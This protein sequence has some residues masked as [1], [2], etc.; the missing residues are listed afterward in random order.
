[1]ADNNQFQISVGVDFSNV[2]KQFK[3]FQSNMSSFLD[4]PKFQKSFDK[5][6]DDFKKLSNTVTNFNNIKFT[7]KSAIELASQVDELLKKMQSFESKARDSI[8]T[9]GNNR[10]GMASMDQVSKYIGNTRMDNA[11]E[12]LTKAD[13]NKLATSLKENGFQ[14]PVNLG[15]D[16]YRNSAKVMSG[17]LPLAVARN[18]GIQYVPVS[19]TKQSF[20]M[21]KDAV[22]ISDISRELSK[23]ANT[24]KLSDVFGS[25][26]SDSNSIKTDESSI[27]KLRSKILN[28]QKKLITDDGTLSKATAEDTLAKKEEQLE[29]QLDQFRSSITKVNTTLDTVVKDAKSKVSEKQSTISEKESRARTKINTNETPVYDKT[30]LMVKDFESLSKEQEILV[31]ENKIVSSI[32][33]NFKDL[34]A[35][36]EQKNKLLEKEKEILASEESSSKTLLQNTIEETKTK[37]KEK[38]TTST[39]K[40]E[41]SS[42]SLEEMIQF[43]DMGPIPEESSSKGS[44]ASNYVRSLQ[45]AE[46]E[47]SNFL[48]VFNT[49]KKESTFEKL[50]N[51]VDGFRMSLTGIIGMLGGKTLYDLL[52]GNN[53]QIE[54]AQQAM[55]ETMKSADKAAQTI[56]RLRSYAALSPFQETETIQSGEMLAS[57]GMDVMKWIN[58]AGDLAAAKQIQ[59]IDLGDVTDVVT[60]INS[61]DFGKAMIRMRQMGISLAD[62]RAQGLEFTKNNTFMGTSDQMLD[63]LQKIIQQRFGGMSQ[64]LGETFTGRISTIKDIIQQ[65]GMDLG[66]D[67]FD[68]LNKSL[69]KAVKQVQEFRDSNE[70][71]KLISDFNTSVDEIKTGIEPV[72]PAVKM[73][74]SL[75]L[76]NLP[77]I[78]AYLKSMFV[79]KGLQAF[80]GG[81][82]SILSNLA[83]VEKQYSVQNELLSEAGLLEDSDNAKLNKI[84]QALTE[85]NA[86]RKLGLDIANETAV[87]E[88]VAQARAEGKYS[89]ARDFY[90]SAS[91]KGKTKS[92][93]KG[94]SEESE[95][96]SSSSSGKGSGNDSYSKAADAMAK[97]AQDAEAVARAGTLSGIAG[98]IGKALAPLSSML[99]M[100]GMILPLVSL[101]GAGINSVTSANKTY[102]RSD[103]YGRM[104]DNQI[105]ER[106]RLQDLNVTR[107]YAHNQVEYYQQQS[108]SSQQAVN[109]AKA[110]LDLNPSDVSL[111][112]QYNSAVQA[113]ANIQHSL[114]TALSQSSQATQRLLTLDPKLASVLI[115]E[116][117]KLSDN[118]G[119]F[120]AN[121]KAIQENIDARDELIAHD[122]ELQLK[123][124]ES[125]SDKSK[126]EIEQNNNL[127]NQLQ[128]SKFPTGASAFFSGLFGTLQNGAQ[129]FNLG[130]SGG[131]LDTMASSYG[132]MSLKGDNRKDA[133]NDLQVKNGELQKN[134][135]TYNQSKADL[136]NMR[137]LG[138]YNSKGVPQYAEYQAYQKR[139]EAQSQ[140]YWNDSEKVA[141]HAQ[142]LVE[143]GSESAGA[144]KNHYQVQLNNVA[145]TKGKD[146]KAYKDLQ[147]K[148]DQAVS[149]AYK[150]TIDDLQDMQKMNKSNKEAQLKQMMSGKL[151]LL[152][153][154][155]QDQNIQIKDITEAFTLLQTNVHAHLQGA[156]AQYEPLIRAFMFGKQ[157]LAGDLSKLQAFTADFDKLQNFEDNQDAIQKQYDNAMLNMQADMTPASD[158]AEQSDPYQDLQDKWESKLSIASNHKDIK[159]Q[160]DKLNNILEGSTAYRNDQLDQ[161]KKIMDVINGYIDGLQK[162]IPT[163]SNKDA[164]DAR[165]KVTDLQKQ[166]NDLALEIKDQ[167]NKNLVENFHNKWDPKVQ[168]AED[169]KIL[170]LQQDQLNSNFQGSLKYRQDLVDSDKK[171]KAIIMQEIDALKDMIPKISDPT[172]RTAQQQQL[173]SLQ[174]KANDLALEIADKT[175]K[176][177]L[178]AFQE[179]WNPK[180]QT[181]DLKKQIALQQDQL[182]NFDTDSTKYQADNRNYLYAQS[183]TIASAIKDL[184]TTIPKLD[185]KEQIQAQ[186]Q[187]L[188]LQKDQNSI[189][190]EIKNNTSKFGE[191]NKPSF[192]KAMTYYDYM[193]QDSQNK[194]VE[195]ANAEFAFKIDAPQSEQEVNQLM[196]LIQQTI[197]VKVGNTDRNGVVNPYTRG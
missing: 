121:T 15:V 182:N 41:S 65:I 187:L 81:I 57:N 158:L 60:R 134:V 161:D 162:L 5:I 138:F 48:N 169:Q 74:V 171:T 110:K 51:S 117:G 3:S 90:K 32:V 164:Q 35:V 4:T 174:Q 31:S 197:G 150:E 136:A 97:G 99:G 86:L 179:K 194:A 122:K 189:L 43:D 8:K 127:I 92:S 77:T 85:I 140:S 16:P 12:G 93:G 195:I 62:F 76:E 54:I 44:S 175:N 185:S 145:K 59:G 131:F 38:P 141:Q 84:K 168:A 123:A 106:N 79:I 22:R 30:P 108:T 130:K 100:A 83:L 67:T 24:F 188:Q 73:F 91:E 58:N 46:K 34:V 53:A 180:M 69:A 125:D 63:A 170:R 177:M 129:L 49:G 72:L 47:Y 18:E 193:T 36:I 181:D 27:V 23:K 1:M 157:G 25:N 153:E 128:N 37:E 120:D 159:L 2:E 14:K 147:K 82:N 96:T 139:L 45:Q 173:A 113:N 61:G 151:G 75:L 107:E 21:D 118:T 7:N 172:E 9:L 119:S 115:D 87:A 184:E 17:D 70:L 116:N 78:V 19:A 10:V 126:K 160:Q 26:I 165:V 146:S 183:K 40:V 71:G 176:D 114:T 104:A 112:K 66:E 109:S 149:E 29:K 190:L 64:A 178:G 154:V 144:V 39:K 94:T 148:R 11:L 155:F 103:D 105:E 166:A 167:T 137:K 20:E 132:K 28:N 101:V 95:E 191:F 156:I 152:K 56:Q 102:Y 196:D 142:D 111:Q 186:L 68:G 163:L 143:S 88:A 55:Q 6:N 52:I 42:S 133:I 89:V 80:L 98:T 135:E 33:E 192:V 50:T 124:Q 13:Y